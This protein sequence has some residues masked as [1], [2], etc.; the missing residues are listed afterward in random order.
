MTFAAAGQETA[1][2]FMELGGA[3]LVLAFAARLATWLELSPIAFYLLGGL[4]LGVLSPA[5]LTE[6]FVEVS[7]GIGVV[8]L[9]FLLG[10]EY[11][12]DELRANLRS[13][14]P[15]GLLDAALNFTPGFL[16][17]LL[18]GWSLPAA[19]VLGGVTW[20]SS[21]GIAAKALADLGRLGNRETPVVLSLLVIEDLAMVAYLPL[22]AALLVGSGALAAVESFAIAAAAAAITLLIAL[23]FGDR[24]G[25]LVE[26]RSQE[27]VMLTALG[28]VLLIAGVAERLQV[29]AAVGAF[30]VGIAFSGEIAN[31]TRDLLMPLRDLAAA[32]FF[33]FFALQI[34]TGELPGVIGVAALLAAVTAATKLVTGWWAARAAGIGAAGRARA[35]AALVARG[36]FSIVIAGLAVAAGT[37]ERL[38]SLAAAYVL[39][40]ALGGPLLM[41]YADVL[42][43]VLARL[44]RRPLATAPADGVRSPGT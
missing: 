24:V 38:G 33:L 11:S 35:G 3:L 4:L 22:I 13:Q 21:S 44:D 1:Q 17:G 31:R 37:E 28:L 43:P 5:R 16:A 10:L 39:L 26:H 27:V 36:E 30:L 6:D 32:L 40:L 2:A 42:A 14:A 15:A 12:A 23:R 20:I 34:D 41:K 9:L 25:R 18:L 8:L 19:M 7:A 29:S